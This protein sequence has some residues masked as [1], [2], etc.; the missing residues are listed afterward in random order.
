MAFI[1][2]TAL[3]DSVLVLISFFVL[4]GRRGQSTMARDFSSYL[5]FTFGFLALL[6]LSI[7]QFQGPTTGIGKILF[8]LAD[9]SLWASLWYMISLGLAN[10]SAGVRK[11]ALGVF[12]V[13]AAVGSLYQIAGFLGSSIAIQPQIDWV[14]ANMAPVL[15]YVVWVPV[16]FVFI[17]TAISTQD[18]I[19][20]AR[21]IMFAAGLFLSTYSW[22]ARLQLNVTSLLIIS[23]VSVIGF[24]CLVGGVIYRDTAP[25]Q[26]PTIQ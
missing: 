21:S 22:A 19:V 3:I 14:L 26:T 6:A 9:F 12:A 5:V 11:R 8:V 10:S 23:G 4:K 1:A 25:Q 17:S 13:L 24:I 20:R 16:G 2:Y 15:M 18:S 7:L